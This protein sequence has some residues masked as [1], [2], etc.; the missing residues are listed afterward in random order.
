MVV[1]IIFNG[2]VNF[3]LFNLLLLGNS[4]YLGLHKSF[5]L[6]YSEKLGSFMHIYGFNIWVGF[7]LILLIGLGVVEPY[8]LSLNWLLV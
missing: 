1:S 2:L 5:Q 4:L 7:V 3:Y 6:S 8:L